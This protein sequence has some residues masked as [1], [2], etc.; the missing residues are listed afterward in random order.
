MRELEADEDEYADADAAVGKRKLK[1]PRRL[2]DDD[3]SQQPVI[4]T[5]ADVCIETHLCII[6]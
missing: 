1:K 5:A 3:D 2:D 4:K 6:P